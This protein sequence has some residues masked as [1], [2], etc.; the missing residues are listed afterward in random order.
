MLSPLIHRLRPRFITIDSSKWHEKVHIRLLNVWFAF[1]MT[2][3]MQRWWLFSCSQQK[4]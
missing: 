1:M 2:D 3:E 4:S